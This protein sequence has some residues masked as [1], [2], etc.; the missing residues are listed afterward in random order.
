MTKKGNI[1]I[2]GGQEKHRDHLKMVLENTYNVTVLASLEDSIEEYKGKVDVVLA[3]VTE[4]RK[5]NFTWAI[6]FLTDEQTKNIPLIAFASKDYVDLETEC[7]KNGVNQYL[8][9]P[10]SEE[11]INLRVNQAFGLAE[12][13]FLRGLRESNSIDN[14]TG[15]YK[16]EYFLEETVKLIKA[17]PDNQYA[18]I[19]F[20]I[21]KFHMYNSLYGKTEGDRFIKYLGD[22]VKGMAKKYK[23]MLYCHG[24]AD[25]FYLCTEY[26]SEEK[27][28]EFFEDVR[29]ELNMYRTDYDF[30][31][32]FGVYVVENRE[33]SGQEM[34]G[35]ARF[36]SK[37]CKGRYRQNY[38][39]Y[40]E[41][42]T[43]DLGKEQ[44]VL[45]NMNSALENEHF[46][47]YLQP[48]YELINN[49]I[50][51]AEA[52]VRWN[53]P[54]KGLIS[55][56][57]FI[58][59]FEKNGFISELDYY[60]WE[61]TCALIRKWIDEGHQPN[62][63]SVNVSRVSLYNPLIAEKINDLVNRYRIPQSLLHLE[64]TES[65]YTDNPALIRDTI[66]KLHTMGFKI[67]MDDFGSGYSSLNVLKDIAVDILKI[68]MKFMEKS[69]IPGR[70][71]NI[72][73]SVVRMA[74]WL[75][76]P[77]I[78]EGVETNDQAK[79]LR[80]IGCEYVQGYYFA[81]P[82]PVDQ[83]E[84]RAFQEIIFH[85][86]EEHR[87][88]NDSLWVSNE[89]MET[90]FSNML[91]PVAIFEYDGKEDL[92][93]IRVNNAFYD[94]FGYESFAS[95]TNRSMEM[96]DSSS[97]EGV[98]AA[99]EQVVANKGVA[100]CEF[101][102]KLKR[103][104]RVWVNMKLKYLSNVADRYIIF[105]TLSDVTITKEIDRELQRY[106]RAML[107]GKKERQNILI[108]DDMKLNRK[109]LKEMFEN[110]YDILEADNGKSAIELIKKE[111]YDIDMILLD[112]AMPVMSGEEFLERKSL[113]D[114]MI[115]IPVIIISSNDSV[116]TQVDTL[117]C[118]VFDYITKPYVTEVVVRRVK[119]VL[120]ANSRI[121]DALRNQ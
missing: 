54:E 86:V 81:R 104:N 101:L 8:A 77:V 24:E 56:G 48:K 33:L 71:E 66:N 61:K 119:N 65:A 118:G 92:E 87:E 114:K 20:D 95:Y 40:T 32:N 62:P 35:L 103:G 5:A 38:A 109:V 102:V 7:A 76:M 27:L 120:D 29:T 19:N 84:I 115:G 110:E 121:I 9:L 22:L 82:M 107:S 93:A 70:S 63:V 17:N 37:K 67:L 44:F 16:K 59:I 41:E 10:T 28:V 51:G 30:L 91:Q 108:I 64:L 21:Y 2:I 99:F 45:N 98:Q 58:P 73:A 112:L 13:T 31:P 69:E 60:V 50:R 90:L 113:D 18:V 6:K 80:S 34:V 4:G 79:F 49:T 117:A 46:V 3:G 85:E 14:M 42:M 53:D 12:L 39:F 111:N 15:V 105:A 25:V 89:Q 43:G 23:S 75:N 74:K 72:L 11:V 68:D 47:I 100:E 97:Q 83:Y 36:A 106:K 55:P 52:L 94:M 96:V 57:D 78:A 116:Q 88:D 1:L 26:E